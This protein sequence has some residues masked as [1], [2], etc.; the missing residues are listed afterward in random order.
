MINDSIAERI[1]LF[2]ENFE[3]LKNISKKSFDEFIS[4]PYLQLS[5]ERLLQVLIEII[6]DIGNYLINILK[7]PKPS[8]YTDVFRILCEHNVLPQEMK[9]ELVQMAQFRNLLVHGYLKIDRAWIYKIMTENTNSLVKTMNIL[10]S[11]LK[12][13]TQKKK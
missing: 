11:K 4:S 9:N 5:A 1:N 12:E 3:L 6:L 10:V 8:T 2:Y 7:L 13:Q